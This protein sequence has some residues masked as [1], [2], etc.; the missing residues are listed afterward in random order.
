MLTLIVIVS[1]TRE[2]HS[3]VIMHIVY[4]PAG[5]SPPLGTVN[6]LMT[7]VEQPETSL[8]V[9]TESTVQ[10]AR[11]AVFVPEGTATARRASRAT[12]SKDVLDMIQETG[13]VS[14]GKSLGSTVLQRRPFV[15][16]GDIDT[17]RNVQAVGRTVMPGCNSFV[18][19][20]R[21][22]LRLNVRAVSA[23]RR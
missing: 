6:A 12:K 19:G 3:S 8:A 22:L 18:Y 16:W 15:R 23:G 1:V 2:L 13:L 10:A 5:Y 14:L 7:T 11:L 17:V 4:E 21:K 9:E 20:P